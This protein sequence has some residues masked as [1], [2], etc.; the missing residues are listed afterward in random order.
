MPRYHLNLINVIDVMDEDGAE[1]AD[2]AAAKAAAIGSAREMMAA[3]VRNGRPIDLAHRIEV[4]SSDGM[5]LA[6]IKFRELITIEDSE[7]DAD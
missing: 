6:T 3:H 2:L 5:V 4:A 7:A 1:Y